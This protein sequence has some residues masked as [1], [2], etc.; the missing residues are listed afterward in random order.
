MIIGETGVLVVD[1]CYLPST[2]EEDIAQIV[3]GQA[4]RYATCLIRTGITITSRGMP[5]T[6]TLFRALP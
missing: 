3:S 1:S 4:S 6:R 5:R 2:A